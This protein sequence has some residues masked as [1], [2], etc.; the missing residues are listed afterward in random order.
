VRACILI[1]DDNP[2]NLKLAS[3][4]LEAEGYTVD[5]A[6]D[7]E[8]AQELLQ[9][10][11]PDLI[12]MD[13]ALPGMDGLTLT[14]KLKADEKLM[15]IPVIAMTAFAMKGDDQK[16]RDAGCNGYITKPIDTRKFPQQ[17]AAFL[18]PNTNK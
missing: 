4:V 6:V 2:T 14:R 12:L 10:M 8:Q 5:L 16:A 11:T 15:H 3:Q 18:R 1:V 9:H 7:A 17:V 13:I